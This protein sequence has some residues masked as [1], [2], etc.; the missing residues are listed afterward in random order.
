M[1]GI[2]VVFGGAGINP[3]REFGDVNKLKQALDLLEKKGVKN[4]DTATLYGQSEQI[5]G[6][7]G[8]GQRFTLDTKVRGGFG[9]GATKELIKSETTDSKKKLGT[10]VDIC[11]VHAP[12][13]KTPLDEQL[14]AINEV[15]QSGFFKRFGLSNYKADDVQKI[16]DHCK[17]KGYVL[18]SVYQGNYSAVARLQE[19][20]LFPTLR[21][22]GICFYAYS[23]LAGGFLT[24]TKEQIKEGTGRFNSSGDPGMYTEMYSKTPLLEALAEWEQIA[25]DEGISRADLAYRWVRYNSPLKQEQGDAIIIGARN[26]EQLQETLDSI[27]GGKLSDNATKRIDAI[28]EKIKAD[29][30]LDNYHR[31]QV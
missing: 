6:E 18:P 3:G 2:K 31:N 16:Y 15:H 21:K 29:A 24:K 13:H 17:E 26:L 9:D 1:S 22:L 23:P 27:N 12:D 14:S 28:W 4:I 10:S 7:A 5:L 11:Y 30:P 20:I 19:T 8:A 25:E